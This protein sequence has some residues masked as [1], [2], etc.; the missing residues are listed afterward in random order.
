MNSGSENKHIPL[1]IAVIGAIAT[2]ITACITGFFG[3][4][5]IIL[6]RINAT[7]VTQ[8]AVINPPAQ[9]QQAS[10]TARAIL[11]AGTAA[12]TVPAALPTPTSQP[13]ATPEPAPLLFAS[14]ISANGLALDPGITFPASITTLYAV[15]P[16]GMA[17]PGT[18]ISVEDAR[19][20]KYY[21]FLRVEPGGTLKTLGWRWIS[22]GKTVNEYEMPVKTGNDI[23]LGYTGGESGIFTAAPFGLGKYTI[24]IML[25]GNVFL[26][27]ALEITGK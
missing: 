10:P 3:V 15:F 17:P 25:G 9:V 24:Q 6:N 18:R 8:P 27:G 22:K 11:A 12:T 4:L 26:S 23:W 16:A 14:R 13:S 2:V 5:P 21:A 19:P 20:G 1:I 7:P